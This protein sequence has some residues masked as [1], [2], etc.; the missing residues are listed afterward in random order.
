MANKRNLKKNISRICGALAGDAIMAG[1]FDNVDRARVEGIVRRAAALQE[2][3]RARVTFWFDKSPRD[4]NGDLRAYHKAR[5]AYFRAG[6]DKLR[7]EFSHEA[8]SIVKELNEAV[9][10]EVRRALTDGQ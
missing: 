7:S 8:I 3:S 6:Y 5:R 4:F 1:Y 2:T 10:A 9:P